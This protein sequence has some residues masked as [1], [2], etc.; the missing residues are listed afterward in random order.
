MEYTCSLERMK[1][2]IQALSKFR[3]T[4]NGGITRLSLSKA[5]LGLQYLHEN[6]DTLD[7]ELV[8]TTGKI[9]AYPNIHT[10]IP[11]EVRITID[12]AIMTGI[13]GYSAMSRPKQICYVCGCVLIMLSRK[14][15]ADC[16]KFPAYFESVVLF[17]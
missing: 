6:L 10:I 14:F 5:A 11:D 8:Y 12:A 15:P 1:D 2:K 7:E 17:S 16:R 3:D 4:G 9:S 13:R